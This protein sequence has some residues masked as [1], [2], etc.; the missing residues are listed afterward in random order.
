MEQFSIGRVLS[1][2]FGLVR[3][4]IGTV[5]LFVLVVVVVQALTGFLAQ[6]LAAGSQGDLDVTS[7]AANLARLSALFSTGWSWLFILISVIGFGLSYAGGI[8]G[9]AQQAERGGTTLAQC[10]QVGLTR[11]VPVIGLS[12]LWWLGIWLGTVFL[13]VPGLILLSMWSVAL[14]AQ[15]V[16]G[17]GII[18][19][20][21]RSRELTR[22]N[23]LSIFGVL[24]VLFLIYYAVI[25][26]LFGALLGTGTLGLGNN[27]QASLLSTVLS[28]PAACLSGMLLKSMITSIYLESVL[29]KEGMRTHGLTEV[30]E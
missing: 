30:F 20:F 1:R 25:I 5:G 14:P 19:S 7:P 11:M 24:F 18:D 3:D 22:G 10:F 8:H 16:E 17:R 12:I 2:G 23:R 27:G 29:V 28:I 13:I 15:I 26:I 4:T 9:F 6:A 21:G